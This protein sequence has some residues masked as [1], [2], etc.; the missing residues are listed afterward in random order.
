MD[1]FDSSENRCGALGAGC[2]CHGSGKM[3]LTTRSMIVMLLVL[4]VLIAVECI[5]GLLNTPDPAPD[6]SRAEWHENC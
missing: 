2:G 1:S 4:A 3:R 5:C 6:N